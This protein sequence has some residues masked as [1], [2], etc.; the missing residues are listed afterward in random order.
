MEYNSILA[1]GQLLMV[2]S[3]LH[4]GFLASV[5]PSRTF[6]Q[7]KAMK[8]GAAEARDIP[9]EEENVENEI[10]NNVNFQIQNFPK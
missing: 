8:S 4:R 10:Q 3:L 5:T 9:M 7:P 1:N 2:V 6:I